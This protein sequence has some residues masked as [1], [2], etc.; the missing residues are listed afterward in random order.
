MKAIQEVKIVLNLHERNIIRK[1]I[2]V[3]LKFDAE[4]F[5]FGHYGK[6][7]ITSQSECS[8]EIRRILSEAKE[9]GQEVD[10]D[11][12]EFIKVNLANAFGFF[13][14]FLEKE[15]KEIE[16]IDF[17]LIKKHFQVMVIC[18][19]QLVYKWQVQMNE[20]NDL[21]ESGNDY[22]K[23]QAKGMIEYCQAQIDFFTSHL[24]NIKKVFN[25]GYGS[26]DDN[27][28]IEMLDDGNRVFAE[29]DKNQH[30]LY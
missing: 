15:Y 21:L 1:S 13:H 23:S 8:G 5:C 12:I 24:D 4:H 2:P 28:I 25:D 18:Y 27:E 16:P 9:S 7:K 3:I 26:D 6:T 14:V 19:N 17:G 11:D 10:R 30:L 22:Q 20:C 29:I